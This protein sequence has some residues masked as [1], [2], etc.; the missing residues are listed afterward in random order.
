M[1]ATQQIQQLSTDGKINFILTYF[2]ARLADCAKIDDK[3]RVT[4]GDEVFYSKT[5]Y[6]TTD[7]YTLFKERAVLVEGF[8]GLSALI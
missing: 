3:Y 6:L 1:N 7:E 2:P 5:V 8:T 4:L